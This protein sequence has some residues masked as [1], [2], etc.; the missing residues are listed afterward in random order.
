MSDR[1]EELSDL[2]IEVVD[3]IPAGRV[4]TFGAIADYLGRGGPRGVAGV[5]ARHGPE[6][7]WWRVVRAD[8]TLPPYLMFDAQP[9]WLIEGTPIRHGIVDVRRALWQPDE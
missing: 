2:V 9:H 6:V 7:A 1:P 5:M 4:M 3:S 8:G